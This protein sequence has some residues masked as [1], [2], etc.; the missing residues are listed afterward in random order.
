LPGRSGG[1]S[2]AAILRMA[3]GHRDRHHERGKW[4]R[5]RKKSSGFSLNCH[6]NASEVPDSYHFLQSG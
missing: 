6:G 4:E 1:R 3:D 5:E 2:P